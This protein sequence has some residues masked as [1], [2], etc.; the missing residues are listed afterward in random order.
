MVKYQT[1]VTKI[2]QQVKELVDIGI[3]I[4]FNENAPEELAEISLL[5]TLEELK[6]NVEKGDFLSIDGNVFEV[7][8]VGYE[9]NK[10]LS[11]LGHCCLKF[12]KNAEILPG[13]IKLSGVTP[14]VKVG[15]KI[16]IF[17]KEE[18]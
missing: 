16:K 14:D 17:R 8:E 5:H 9:A 15:S 10:N 2:G 6:E 11:L 3:L 4:I 1:T 12:D 13:D 7:L 18:I